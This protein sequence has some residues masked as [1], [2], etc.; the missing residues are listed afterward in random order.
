MLVCTERY[1]GRYEI[2]TGSCSHDPGSTGSKTKHEAV[3][4]VKDN[5]Q[6][7][8]NN[9]QWNAGSWM[10]TKS[11]YGAVEQQKHFFHD[12]SIHRTHAVFL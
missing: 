2:L 11:K 4:E 8:R 6:N 12:K 5:T 1:S 9:F 3:W 10:V 7:S